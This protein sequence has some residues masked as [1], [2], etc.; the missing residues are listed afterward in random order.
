MI[1]IEGLKGMPK[2]KKE[3]NLG[4]ILIKTISNQNFALKDG[5]ILCISSKMCSIAY[6]HIVNLKQIVPSNI[7]QNIHKKIPRKS[8]E[9]IQV[10]LDQTKDKTGKKLQISD[11]YI[12]GWLPNGLFLTSAGVDRGDNSQVVV[13]PENCDEIAKEI[14]ELV[15]NKLKIKVGII[16]TDSDGR[17]DKKGATQIAV[18][19][20]GLSGIRI[21]K[22]N[23]KKYV[24]TL[25]DM[26]ASAAGL[27]MGQR[28]TNI[29]VVRIRGVN[30]NFDDK[31][32]IEEALN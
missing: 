16:I 10:I 9:L 31:A 27:V 23:E 25:C 14:G 22:N 3:C 18:G 26:L 28:G 12:G 15:N 32:G 17:I 7:A 20:Y 30:F 11:N 5:D 24:E 21:T 19:L 8:A 2:I 4:E 6:G 13:L 1:S 29:P